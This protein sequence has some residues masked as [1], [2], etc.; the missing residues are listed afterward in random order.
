MKIIKKRRNW[1]NPYIRRNIKYKP[2]VTMKFIFFA[3]CSFL[4][5]FNAFGQKYPES[6]MQQIGIGPYIGYE[7]NA[8]T[9][10]Y[11]VG[12]YYEYRPFK[13]W[14]FTVGASYDKSPFARSTQ[15]DLLRLIYEDL[16]IDIPE[17][18][19]E[20]KQNQLAVNAGA[21]FYM[22]KF[23]VSAGLGWSFLDY[24][25]RD[26]ETAV[27][28]SNKTDYFYHT[29][30]VGYQWSLGGNHL[31]EPFFSATTGGVPRSNGTAKTTLGVRYAYRFK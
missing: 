24:E 6:K 25:V 31:L 3:I 16:G 20:I 30:G 22:S 14:G 8:E 27:Q 26:T 5:A 28:E 18:T 10:V 4:W 9:V 7:S 1:I 2:L 15:D 29:V 17:N 21:R 12:G 19:S 23:F 11:G 13:R